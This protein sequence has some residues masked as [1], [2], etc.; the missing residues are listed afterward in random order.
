MA[1]FSHQRHDRQVQRGLPARGGDRSHAILEGGDA[2]LEDRDGGIRQTRVD[3]AGRLHVEKRRRRVGIRKDVGSRLVDGHCPGSR[4][5][6]GRL[7][8]VDR[9][10]VRMRGF[11]A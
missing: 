1:A 9:Q 8:G 11:G 6:V 10:S 7:A 2:L 3:M 5:R 4:G